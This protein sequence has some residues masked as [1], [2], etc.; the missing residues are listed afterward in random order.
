MSVPRRAKKPARKSGSGPIQQALEEVIDRLP[1]TSAAELFTKKLTEAGIKPTRKLVNK[2]VEHVLAGGPDEFEW[3]GEQDIHLTITPEDLADLDRS[4]KA[5]RDRLPALIED[6]GAKT[7]KKVLKTLKVNW[8]AQHRWESETHDGF[9]SRLETR[10]GDGLN[11]LRMM[12][13]ISREVGEANALKNRRSRAR[14]DWHKRHVLGQLHIRA[15][16]VTAEIITLLENGYADGAMAR[17]RTLYEIGVVATLIADYDDGLAERYLAHEVIDARNALKLYEETHEELGYA[18]PSKAEIANVD[19]LCQA[20]IAQFE[21]EFKGN[22]GWAAKYLGLK[23]PTF[24][25]LQKVAGRAKMRSHYKMASYNVHADVK[26]ITFKHGSLRNPRQVLLG[27]SN[28]GLEEP[29]QNTSI[30]FGQITVLLMMSRPELDD[31]VSMR[32]LVKLQEET[33]DAFVKAGRQLKRE[34]RERQ[35]GKASS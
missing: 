31:I 30:T 23:S 5:F 33:A 35:Q 20:A 9:R 13:T 18:P 25:D 22:Y 7:A 16:Q 32:I 28:A 6:I 11:A 1:R 10:W 4:T 34:E 12:L 3:P 8:A 26:G 2:L 29:G 17:W 21:R 27:A 19:Q 15:C 14:C 24:V